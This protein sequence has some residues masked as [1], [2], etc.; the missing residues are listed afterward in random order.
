MQIMGLQEEY[1]RAREWIS[2]KSTFDR[3]GDFNT[4]EVS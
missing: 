1:N 4:F 2:S 3:D